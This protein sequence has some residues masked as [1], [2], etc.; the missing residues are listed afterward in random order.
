MFNLAYSAED[1]LATLCQLLHEV[2]NRPRSLT[3]QARGWFVQEEQEL[4]LSCQLNSNCQALAL[5]DIETCSGQLLLLHCQ[6]YMT[7]L[8]QAHQQRHPRTPPFPEV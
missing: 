7:N 1:S 6:G 5:F 3:I 8:L 4:R 2:T